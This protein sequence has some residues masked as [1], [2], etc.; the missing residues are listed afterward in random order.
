MGEQDRLVQQCLVMYQAWLL[1]GENDE[2][3]A[4]LLNGLWEI[5]VERHGDI[6]DAIWI[7]CHTGGDA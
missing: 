7:D 5:L 6:C 4:R 1:Y 2:R 3:F